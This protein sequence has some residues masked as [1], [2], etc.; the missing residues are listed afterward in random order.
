MLKLTMVPD[1]YMTINGNIVVQLS[2]IAGGRAELA[3]H[4]DRSVPIIRGAV[5]ERQGGARPECLD[6]PPPKKARYFRDRFFCWNDDREWAVRTMKRVMDELDKK[7]ASEEADILRKQLDRII[8]A[9]WEEEV[10]SK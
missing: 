8:P 9:F 5:L 7:G 2:R 1:E 4:A 3:I 6:A 10:P